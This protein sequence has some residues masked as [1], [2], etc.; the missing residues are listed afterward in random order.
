MT[1]KEALEILK[2]GH[3]VFV[4]GAAG[5]G[6]T[7]L[8]N[9]YIKYLRD[10]GADVGVTAST[11]IAATHMGGMTIHA[12]SGIGVRDRLTEYDLDDL[13]SRSY[14]RKRLLEA[15]V[16]I[17]DE[18]SML[19]HFR[20]DMIE[21]VLRSIRRIDEPFGGLQVIFCGD[22]FQLPPVSR[23]GEAKAMF[24]YHSDIWRN[25]NLKICYLDE[26]FR[27]SDSSYARILNDIRNS[28]SSEMIID[29]LKSR[30]NKKPEIAAEP[31]KLY[32]H[33]ADVDAEN[34]REL[35]KINGE[36]FQYQMSSRGR[37]KLVETV[38]KGCLSPEV[39]R[40]KR[41][42]RVMFVK[43]NFEKGYVNGTLGVVADLN[44]YSIKVRTAGGKIIDV[45]QAKWMIE[46]GGKILAEITQYPL[47]LA[48]AITV[49]KSQGMSLDAAEIDLSKSFE[50]GMGYVAL[51]RL[52]SL[53]GLSLLGLNDMALRVSEEV[54]Q[55][56]RAFREQSEDNADEFRRKNAEAVSKQ[57]K[58]FI[59]KIASVKKEKKPKKNTVEETGKLF[60]S[61]KTTREIASL[62]KLTY[63]T[64]IGHLEKIKEANPY[65]NFSALRDEISVSRTAKIRAAFSKVGMSE[66][67][68]L[69]TPIRNV[70]GD[71]FSFEEIR[72]VRLMM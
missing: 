55:F 5:S 52:R 37:E 36:T 10:S 57:Q 34:E 3:N 49:H 59:S 35:Q 41:G 51:S 66:G 2:M 13:E 4:T 1:Q 16:L 50:R 46:D 15:S 17:I 48:W 32:S 64:I 54:L 61:G 25:M 39:L 24:A 60:L 40:L 7:Y 12:W 58:D 65:F 6:K 26:Q 9:Q 44:D 8:L 72:L 43:N 70:L 31:T 20:L 71:D 19:H 69:L 62:R 28:V 47:R 27:Q 53:G 23:Q 42:A 67:Q 21:K 45:E 11:G 63:G 22:F 29:R 56:D 30:F 18:V 14:L 68:Y 38:K 33:N